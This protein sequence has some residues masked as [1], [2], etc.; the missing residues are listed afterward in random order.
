MFIKKYIY[1]S[2]PSI[3]D[4]CG[5]DNETKET[6]LSNIRRRLTPQ[7]V[8]IRA[9]I[10]YWKN[11]REILYICIFYNVKFLSFKYVDISIL[12]LFSKAGP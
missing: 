3:L 10:V 4:E 1:F 12:E 7:A 11:S 2:D 5:L 9:G 8:R 6:L